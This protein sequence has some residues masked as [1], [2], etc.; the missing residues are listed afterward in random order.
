MHNIKKAIRWL[1]KGK[2]KSPTRK[3][4][5]CKECGQICT[6]KKRCFRCDVKNRKNRTFPNRRNPPEK[7]LKHKDTRTIY[8]AQ[9]YG[10]KK[11]TK[12]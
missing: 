9:K 10:N 2:L 8:F 11:E 12:Q 3:I 5:P 4:H 7:L 1:S 6:G